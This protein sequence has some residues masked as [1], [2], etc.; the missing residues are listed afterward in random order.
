[1]AQNTGS[2][3][4]CPFCSEEIQD[5]AIKCRYCGSDLSAG[6]SSGAAAVAPASPRVRAKD[7]PSYG[8]MTLLSAIIPIIGIIVGIVHLT[9]NTAIDKKLGEHMVVVSLFV[10]FLWAM[11]SGCL[12]VLRA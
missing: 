3:K 5:A 8:M 7:H 12:A 6:R 11:V 9:K 10:V 4:K 2:M 1:M